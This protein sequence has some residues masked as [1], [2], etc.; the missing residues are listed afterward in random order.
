VDENSEHGD[1][2]SIRTKIEGV[3]LQIS[4][5]GRLSL[6]EPAEYLKIST[7]GHRATEYSPFYL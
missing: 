6:G 5:F 4:F 7:G 1:D 3:V 2:E